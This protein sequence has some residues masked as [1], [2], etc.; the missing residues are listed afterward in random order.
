MASYV[1]AEELQPTITVLGTHAR[2][3]LKKLVLGNTVESTLPH[4][5][6]DVLT[7][8]LDA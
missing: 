7:L 6:G 5:Q 8:R 2:G 1:P 3:G 4:L